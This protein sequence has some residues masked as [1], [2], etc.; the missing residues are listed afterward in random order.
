MSVITSYSI[1]YT[2]LY[3]GGGGGGGGASEVQYTGATTMATLAEGNVT[4]FAVGSFMGGP[5]G[6]RVSPA[7]ASGS[8]TTAAGP[9]V[10][11][12]ALAFNQMQTM[13]ANIQSHVEATPN[14]SVVYND[15]IG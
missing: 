13:F 6:Q 15:E 12:A 9:L 10:T 1:H 3:E 4:E 14:V 8:S 7:A 5:S 11:D 2:K